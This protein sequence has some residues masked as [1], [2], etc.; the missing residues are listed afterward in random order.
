MSHITLILWN[1]QEARARAE[2]LERAGHIV[3]LHADSRA[4]PLTLRENPP[5]VFVID[6][7]RLPSH[8][9]ETGVWLRNQKATRYVPIVFIEGDPDKTQRARELM[10]DAVYTNWNKIRSAI[11]QAIQHAPTK[12]IVPGTF[13]SYSGTP[14]PKKLG[15]KTGS[16]VALLGAPQD[17]EQTLGALPESVRVQKQAR[18]QAHVVLLFVKSRAELERRFPAAVRTMAQGGKL[19]MVWP[20]KASGVVTDLTENTV[21]AFGLAAGLVDFKISA[22]DATW[23]GLCFAQRART[24]FS[25]TGRRVGDEG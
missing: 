2:Q 11:K 9:R 23:S 14:L 12:P 24:P 17:F 25:L 5:D 18:D 10:P 4:A 3:T 20:K 13:D 21:R 19:W 15:I 7:S 8:G 6:L 16:V 22:I 1:D